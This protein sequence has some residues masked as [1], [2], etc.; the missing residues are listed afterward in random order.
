MFLTLEFDNLNSSDKLNISFKGN[1]IVIIGNIPEVLNHFLHEKLPRYTSFLPR[2]YFSIVKLLHEN[3]IEYKTSLEYDFTLNVK[4]VC[5][6]KLYDFQEQA[7]SSW[8][9]N[10]KRGTIILP[11][12]SGKTI[13]ALDIISQI[14]KKTLIIVPTLVLI[15]QWKNRISTMLGI[16]PT[17]I[18]EFGGGK[19]EVKGITIITYDSAY[20]YSKRLRTRYGLI[21]L[22]EAHHLTGN[23]TIIADGYIA[24]FRLAL[25][26]TIDVDELAYE[27]L[28][29]KGFGPVV[30][31]KKTSD[32]KETKILSEFTIKT[33]KVKISNIDEYKRLVEVLRN[34]IKKLPR[35]KKIG[36]FQQ[37]I[38][39]INRDPEAAEALKAYK[40]ARDLS[41]SGDEK[42]I[43][44]EELL[45]KHNKDKVIIFSDYVSFCELLSRR[46]LIPCITHR[47]DKKE[48]KWILEYYKRAKSAKIIASKVLDEGIDIPDAKIGIIL[49]GSSSRRQFVQRLGRILRRHPEKDEAILY[50]IISED[51]LEERLSRKRKNQL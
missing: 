23:Y 44:V 31:E 11:T 32:L 4:F 10:N 35:S 29:E 48:R 17:E 51:T 39:R 30:F 12:G 6:F 25:T 19:H 33:Q 20:L 3:F 13:V 15:E 47:T 42:L 36:V 37:I 14:K 9:N 18:G 45:T 46:F 1:E 5:N 16:E 2:N 50:E 49:I 28:M 38:F 7:I 22:D 41:F 26:A 21:I 27:N 43:V 40:K 8:I 24:P 34:Y